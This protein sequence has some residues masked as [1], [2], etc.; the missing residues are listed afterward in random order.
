MFKSSPAALELRDLFLNG[1]QLAPHN[2][3]LLAQ[4]S[5]IIPCRLVYLPGG[6]DG[7][8]VDADIVFEL[9]DGALDA[10]D[11]LDND[12]PGC[13]QLIKQASSIARELS[14]QRRHRSFQMDQV[15]PNALEFGTDSCHVSADGRL[16][17][18]QTGDMGAHGVLPGFQACEIGLD[19]SLP[20]F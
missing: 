2:P 14:P 10:L 11:A 8:H 4:L 20:G 15:D 9:R 6:V 18:F 7:T 3:H 12:G 19:G 5:Q 1:F 17:G 16:P 13:A